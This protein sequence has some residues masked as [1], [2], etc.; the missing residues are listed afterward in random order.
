MILKSTILKIRTIV[1]IE[2]PNLSLIQI[3]KISAPSRTVPFL[4]VN[5]I[6]TLFRYESLLQVLRPK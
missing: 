3:P 5:P 1:P 6:P 4:M 2:M